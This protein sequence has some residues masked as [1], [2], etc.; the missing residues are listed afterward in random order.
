MS[1]HIEISEH[2][3]LIGPLAPETLWFIFQVTFTD[4]D[5]T[6]D[7]HS[8]DVEPV[9]PVPRQRG[10]NRPQSPSPTD[11][12]SP[13]QPSN[14]RKTSKTTR[15][16]G[17]CALSFQKTIHRIDFPGLTGVSQIR[18]LIETP[19]SFRLEW[20]GD[21]LSGDVQIRNLTQELVIFKVREP[22]PGYLITK[23]FWSYII[24]RLYLRLRRSKPQLLITTKWNRRLGFWMEVPRLQLMWLPLV[25]STSVRINFRSRRPLFQRILT[26]PRMRVTTG[27]LWISTASTK[28]GR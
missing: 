11:E 19:D 17:A 5:G 27:E 16:S 13:R 1:T 2:R 21:E 10:T 12:D 26:S 24:F 4:R 9:P 25:V 20:D 14:Q 15:T 18:E 22:S 23:F 6:T 7:F 3:K 8:F 28:F